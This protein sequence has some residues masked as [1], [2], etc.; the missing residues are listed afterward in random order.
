MSTRSAIILKVRKEDLGKKVKFDK[1]KLPIP[2]KNW[3]D[4]WGDESAKEK[5][6]EIT[7]SHEYIGI[8]CHW[9][10]DLDGVGAVLKE[11]F[12]DYDAVLNL[13]AGGD[14]SSIWYDG[15]KH[16]ANR[17]GEEWKYIAPK[18]H[19]LW[20]GVSDNIGHDDCVYVFADVCAIL[21][22][23]GWTFNGKKI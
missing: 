23:D 1:K 13:I 7:L 6:K 18:Q 22:H 15:V 2:L 21:E 20:Y 14:C 4:E 3:K 16:Y 19:E 9:D 17:K 10:G 5:S 12:T 11:Y 8:Y